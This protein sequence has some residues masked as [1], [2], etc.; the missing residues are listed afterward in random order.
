MVRTLLRRVGKQ[1]RAMLLNSRT[2]VRKGKRRL[3]VD[4]KHALPISDDA[5]AKFTRELEKFA[6]TQARPDFFRV[7]DVARRVAG[8]GSLGLERYIV[9]VQGEGGSNG[10]ALL[11]VKQA[12]PSTLAKNEKARQPKWK[13][14][15]DRVVAIQRRM[16]AIA[17]AM[18]HAKKTARGG[19][20]LRELQPSN[21]RLTIDDARGDPHQ[22]RS[23]AKSMGQI[24]AWDQLRSSGRQ[25]SATAEDLIAFAGT[26]AWKKVV[27]DYGR[28][29]AKQVQRDYK[30][31]V[32]AQD[33]IH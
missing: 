11:D 17:P 23:A 30:Q 13:S 26:S 2:T 7:L 29:Y 5:R 19:Y 6:K 21:D 9:L 27:I 25:G 16:Q 20:V 8:L 3:L 10:N 31:F 24:T 4:G 28:R 12:G 32:E 15:A 1:T 33:K 14:D 22:L 18:L